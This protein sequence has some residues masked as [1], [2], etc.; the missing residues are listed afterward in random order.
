MLSESPANSP[1]MNVNRSGVILPIQYLRG[2]AALMVVWHH[3]TGQLDGLS[4]F[5]PWRFGTSGVDVFFVISGFIMVT[6]TA[7]KRTT[8]LDF[9]ARR[10]IRVVPL[11]W[12]LT[13]ILV[14]I[15]LVAPSLFRS[16][17]LTID[18]LAKSLLFIPH[19]S[20]SHKGMI[21]PVLVPGWT[22]NFE[23]FFYAIFAASLAFR[24]PFAVL[25]AT[26]TALVLAGYVWGPFES[27]IARTY[28]HPNLL[29]FLAGAAIAHAWI[30]GATE[31]RFAWS[32]G[33]MLV[34][35]AL[36]LMPGSELFKQ[37]A[38][39][40]GA[41]L[42]VWGALSERILQLR[43]PVLLILG[44]ASYSI[45][46]TH[47]FTLGACRW[48]WVKLGL[49]MPDLSFALTF[50]LTGL[51]ACSVVGWLSYLLIEKPLLR[52]MHNAWRH[53]MGAGRALLREG[54]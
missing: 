8:P 26:L 13:L 51:L 29:E 21:W 16:V 5:F 23:M 42:L 24:R 19:Y 2:L 43:S 14:S 28:T 52:R 33:A 47:I 39:L 49:D 18:S 46:L 1:P 32:I 12:L 54:L 31:P 36:L 15:L 40:A 9:L 17:L 38:H 10:F 22:L 3:G 6:A 25:V 34:G 53:K 7:G 11:Y 37:Y 50:M 20:P 45:Y 27:P 41:S 4:E 44:D 35:T 48:L 30:S